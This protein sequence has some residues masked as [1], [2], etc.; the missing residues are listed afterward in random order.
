MARKDCGV[1]LET[2]PASVIHCPMEWNRWPVYSQERQVR[3]PFVHN[4]LHAKFGQ[5]DVS[6]ALRDQ[7]ILNEG[8][9]A[10]RS[11]RRVHRN[12]LT[13]RFPAVPL[14]SPR[15]TGGSK[16][17]TLTESTMS[18]DDNDTP[19]GHAKNPPGLQRS[20]C[21]ELFKATQTMADTLTSVLNMT[22]GAQEGMD[23][24][25][26]AYG[27][28]HGPEEGTSFQNGV[29][30]GDNCASGGTSCC[31]HE[32]IDGVAAENEHFEH[33]MNLSEDGPSAGLAATNGECSNC[34]IPKTE[35]PEPPILPPTLKEILALDLV[36]ERI[37]RYQA[38]PKSMYTFLCASEFRRDEYP[39]HFLNVHNDIHSGLNGWLEYRC[40]LANNGCTFSLRRLHPNCKG[41]SVVYSHAVEGFGV[42]PHVPDYHLQWAVAPETDTN[43]VTM[44]D[45]ECV[46]R[47]STPEIYTSRDYDSHVQVKGD[48]KSLVKVNGVSQQDC[49]SEV[50]P[51]VNGTCDTNDQ[52]CDELLNGQ[53]DNEKPD[54]FSFLPFE[55]LQHVAR[56]LDG[57]SL[58]NLALTSK[59]L[60]DVACSLLEEKG[61]VTQEWQREKVGDRNHWS[62]GYKVCIC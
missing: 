61:I 1:H 59:L 36:I 60:R 3:V 62:I 29:G 46:S 34:D 31:E 41:S 18:D 27:P 12:N 32:G 15:S 19:W 51:Q 54:T 52:N 39:W 13:L 4:K 9:K 33:C 37:S 47:E 49:L 20:I 44:K 55:V 2:C 11:T 38:K 28:A 30:S 8:F 16:E 42:R 14:K 43:D 53:I 10:P 57:F 6:L 17:G 7:R 23:A 25:G 24:V 56:F 58:C 35:P 26:P 50:E 40:P 21:N 5:L 22:T 48:I 45:G